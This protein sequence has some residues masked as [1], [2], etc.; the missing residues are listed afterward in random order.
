MDQAK[1]LLSKGVVELVSNPRSPGFYS[2]FF[3]VPK[4]ESGK[5]RSILDLSAL[6]TFIRRETFKMETAE[7]I[8]SLLQPGEWL[9]SLD[10]H[11]AYFHVCIHKK[12]RKY[13][14]FTCGGQVYQFRVLPMGLSSSGRVFS[15]VIKEIK[16]FV[17]LLHLL[18]Q[19]PGGHQH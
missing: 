16:Q 4:R 18:G 11:D 19:L 5:W 8:R 2:R 14:R 9:T 10:L 1:L 3:V 12:H 17:H 6:N 7:Q 15:R 13:L